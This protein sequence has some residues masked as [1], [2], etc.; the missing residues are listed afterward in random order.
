VDG[1]QPEEPESWRRDGTSPAVA[2]LCGAHHRTISLF[3]GGEKLILPPVNSVI[4]E[5]AEISPR[6]MHALCCEC[7]SVFERLG[8]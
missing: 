2:R 6:T 7:P 8:K 3:T 1:E 5:D 4:Q